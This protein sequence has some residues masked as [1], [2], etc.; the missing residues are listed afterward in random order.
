MGEKNTGEPYT[1]ITCEEAS[2]K[3]RN[4]E[5]HIIDV[6]N[7]DEYSSGH[8]PNSIHISVDTITSNIDKLPESGELLFICAAGA[9][10]GLACEFAAAFSIDENRLFNI[11]EGVPTWIQKGFPSEQGL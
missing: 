5:C 6:R 3:I 4:G 11:F 7:D 1:R 9:R 8:I 10:S 2:E